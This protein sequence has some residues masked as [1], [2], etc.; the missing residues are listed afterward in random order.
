MSSRSGGTGDV[1]HPGDASGNVAAGGSAAADGN[2]SASGGL[3]LKAELKTTS[4]TNTPVAG[5]TVQ[6]PPNPAEFTMFDWDDLVAL[7]NTTAADGKT[8]IEV[9][10]SRFFTSHAGPLREYW[11]RRRGAAPDTKYCILHIH[12]RKDAGADNMFQY[13]THVNARWSRGGNVPTHPS[14]K[15]EALGRSISQTGFNL[16]GKHRQCKPAAALPT[17]RWVAV[18]TFRVINSLLPFSTAAEKA[19]FVAAFEVE[20][21]I[22]AGKDACCHVDWT[23]SLICVDPSLAGAP[24][25]SRSWPNRLPP[26]TNFTVKRETD[27]YIPAGNESGWDYV[28]HAEPPAW[29][30]KPD[31]VPWNKNYTQTVPWDALRNILIYIE[32]ERRRLMP[33]T[34]PGHGEAE[35]LA[36]PIGKK[37]FP[38]GTQL[39]G[40]GK[41]W[42]VIANAE[43]A[44]IMSAAPPPLTRLQVALQVRV[45]QPRKVGGVLCVS[46]CCH[47]SSIMPDLYTEPF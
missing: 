47:T 45:E 29:P 23:K 43:P 7:F 44:D 40:G 14:L 37:E 46:L 21:N 10:M 42:R 22:E 3:K 8:L 33:V 35:L 36:Q 31:H 4:A 20:Y 30:A 19:S 26:T 9:C 18:H 24:Y 39:K 15:C 25:S 16:T 2:A 5:A 28:N 11:L 12:F 17:A 32:S 13:I 27:V 6:T 38:D 41:D 34:R 1:L